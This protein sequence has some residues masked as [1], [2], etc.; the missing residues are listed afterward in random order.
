[1]FWILDMAMHSVQQKLLLAFLLFR[2]AVIAQAPPDIIYYNGSVI[3]RSPAHPAAQAVAVHGDRF[4]AIGANAEVLKTA[5]PRTRKIDLAG[6]CM[7]PGIIESHVH[8]ISAGLAEIDGPLPL[9]HSIAEIQSFIRSHAQKLPSDRLIFVPKVYSTRLNEHRYPNC[10]EIDQAARSE[11]MIDNATPPGSIWRFSRNW[12]HLRPRRSPNGRI[13]KD[14]NGEPTG[15]IRE[16]RSF[17]AA[18]PAP[19]HREG[20]PWAPKIC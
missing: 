1:M 7:V 9:L 13:V 4:G 19:I 3:P 17:W 20:T 11:A 8:P 2:V 15:L 10:Y 6:K 12:H 5:G 16:R 18:A 14:E